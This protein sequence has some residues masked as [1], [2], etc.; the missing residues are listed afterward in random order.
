MIPLTPS[1]LVAAAAV[2]VGLREEGGD[3]HGPM[4]ELFLRGVSQPPGQPWCAAFVHHVGYWSHFESVGNQSSWPLPPTASCYE[5]G[6]FARSRGILKRVPLAGDVFLLFSPAHARFAHTGV[7]VRVRATGGSTGA[8]PWFDCDT[9]EGNTNDDG[10]REG[11]GVLRKVRRF[12]PMG[13]DRF[14]RWADLDKRDLAGQ[15]ITTPT[16]AA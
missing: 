6:A 2:L 5:L 13:G 15:P 3:N 11:W 1:F 4:V 8:E 16:P 9:I 10:G 7:V 12:Y 14:I